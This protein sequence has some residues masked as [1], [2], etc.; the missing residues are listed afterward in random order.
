MKESKKLLNTY[1]KFV[2]E[3]YEAINLFYKH[4]TEL[5]SHFLKEENFKSKIID[6]PLYRLGIS[7]KK[8]INTKINNLYSIITN[9]SFFYSLNKSLS[10]LS[11]ILQESKVKLNKNN[12]Q[13]DIPPLLKT[14]FQ[15]YEQIES[16]VVDNYIKEKYN[17][18][19]VGLNEEK[20]EKIILLMIGEQSFIYKDLI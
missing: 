2:N 12:I 1:K 13:K 19:L 14:L 17:K 4:L 11:D 3:Y 10:N 9:D 8:A 6:S 5:V 20:L 15:A 7:I 16:K 18:Q